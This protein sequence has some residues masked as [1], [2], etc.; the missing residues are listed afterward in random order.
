MK[1]I[2]R[3]A[4][5]VF[6]ATALTACISAR[7][8]EPMYRTVELKD[9]KMVAGQKE[10]ME[11]CDQCHPGGEAGVGPAINNKPLPP[12]LIKLQIRQGIG[13]MPSFRP[14][15]LSDEEVDAIADYLV[16]LRQKGKT[17]R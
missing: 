7:R 14:D 5:A 9:Q 15:Q 11:H 8:G 12:M 13:V 16:T 3:A 17:K 1:K 4:M 6:V 2:A 10:F